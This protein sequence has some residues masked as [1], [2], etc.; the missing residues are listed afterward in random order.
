MTGV[1][2][3]A[4]DAVP[5]PGALQVLV[6]GPQGEVPVAIV[7][8]SDGSLH[9][10]GDT[11]SHQQVS[12]SEG[13]VEDGRIECWLHGSQFDLRTGH[14]D[15]LPAVTAV[16]VYRLTLDGADVLVDVTATIDTPA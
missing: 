8:D 16:P 11:C 4:A 15:S 1:R 12:L 7:R 13:E 3:C 9:A 6:P 2:V 5:S 10:I 14:P